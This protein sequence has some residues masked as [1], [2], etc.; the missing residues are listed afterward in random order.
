MS[1]ERTATLDALRE[2]KGRGEIMKTADDAAEVDAPDGF[3]DSPLA[4][5]DKTAISIRIDAD[6]LAFFRSH[7]RG[8][9]TR[10]NT[11]LR[12]YMDAKKGNRH[13][14]NT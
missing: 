7:G 8:Y 9:Q 3:W 12:S 11:V 13:R 4:H 14:D 6:V 5:D 1:N 10:M 2:M